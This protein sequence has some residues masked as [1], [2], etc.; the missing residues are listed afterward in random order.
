[1]AIAS[2]DVVKLMSANNKERIGT[3]IQATGP[4]SVFKYVDPPQNSESRAAEKQDL[5]DSILFDTFTPDMSFEAL[6]GFGS[7][8]G[9]AIKNAMSLGYIKRA[10]R[11]EIYGDLFDREISVIKTVLGEMNVGMAAAI[12]A[13]DIKFEFSEPFASDSFEERNSI[14]SLYEAGLVSLEEAVSLLALT[15]TPEAEIEKLRE[16]KEDEQG[17][18][19]QGGRVGGVPRERTE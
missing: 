7:I 10:N 3:L 1:M 9:V 18:N 6:K 15:K 4:D 16:A 8:S 14:A 12:G 17:D 13:L 11:M 2:A 19:V 5:K